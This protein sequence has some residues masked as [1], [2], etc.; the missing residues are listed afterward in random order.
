MQSAMDLFDSAAASTANVAAAPE[1]VDLGQQA[2]DL[3]TATNAYD[4]NARV[5]Q[6]QNAMIRATLDM[7]A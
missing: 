1:A 2:V 5:L 7:L 6:T 3:V 4:I